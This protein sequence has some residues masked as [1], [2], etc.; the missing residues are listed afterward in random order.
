MQVTFVCFLLAFFKLSSASFVF[1][2]FLHFDFLFCCSYHLFFILR[3]IKI[4]I[5]D[6]SLLLLLLFLPFLKR[7]APREQVKSNIF[8]SI[9]SEKDLDCFRRRFHIPAEY[10]M[11]VT[12]KKAHEPYTGFEKLVVYKNQMKGGLR[13]TLDPFVKLFLNRYNITPGQLHPNSYKILTG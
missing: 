7:M 5:F 13:F 2:R 8:E 10:T 9:V 3:W 6:C 12:N 1:Q 11:S 4:L